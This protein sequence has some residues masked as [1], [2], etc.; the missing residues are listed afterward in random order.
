VGL[1]YRVSVSTG[2]KILHQTGIADVAAARIRRQT[3]L[4][5]P[6]NQHVR[7]A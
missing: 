1:G 5:A 6:I 7:A 2:W 4:G 3:I